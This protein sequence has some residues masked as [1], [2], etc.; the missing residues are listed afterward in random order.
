MPGARRKIALRR[1][2]AHR[3]G[4]HLRFGQ[5]LVRCR[6]QAHGVIHQVSLG[7]VAGL[8]EAASEFGLTESDFLDAARV[9]RDQGFALNLMLGAFFG[10][11]L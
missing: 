2:R 1:H 8:G 3:F 9:A 11:L 7:H 5:H 10:S 6:D 4:P